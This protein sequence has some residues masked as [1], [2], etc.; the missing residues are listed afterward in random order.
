MAL[1]N[2]PWVVK[3]DQLRIAIILIAI[4]AFCLLADS[5]AGTVTFL[6]YSLPS[7]CIFQRMTGFDCPGCGLTRALI[8]ALQG[9]FAESY[10]MHIWGIPLAFL[11][12]TQIPNRLLAGVSKHEA[13]IR[14]RPVW[15]NHF[16]FLS[17]LLPW[18]AKTAATAVIL[19][20]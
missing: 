16:V 18:A 3:W 20:L 11:L 5:N 2:V 9:R 6:G 17:F 19:L 4:V 1:R 15:A 12:L 7:M 8:L 14:F 10:Y 13:V